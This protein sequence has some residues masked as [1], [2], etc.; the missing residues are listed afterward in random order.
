MLADE[1]LTNPRVLEFAMAV[2]GLPSVCMEFQ[3]V[4][5]DRSAETIAD[6]ERA[7]HSGFAR[8]Q[9]VYESGPLANASPEVKSRF[10]K[11]MQVL[12]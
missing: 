4:Y 2:D 9:Q 3:K 5:A 12:D 1:V 7:I 11:M 10:L 6:V 8:M